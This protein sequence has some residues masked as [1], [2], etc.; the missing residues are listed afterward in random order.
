MKHP[1]LQRVVAF[2]FKACQ[3]CGGDVQVT[4]DESKCLNCG[5]EKEPA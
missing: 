2:L 1:K 4:D 5:H 3:K